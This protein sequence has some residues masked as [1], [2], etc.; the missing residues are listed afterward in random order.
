MKID[1]KNSPKMELCFFEAGIW[2]TWLGL[3]NNAMII[4]LTKIYKLY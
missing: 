4:M 1:F 3:H 2:Y